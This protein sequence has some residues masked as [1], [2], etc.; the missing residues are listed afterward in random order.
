MNYYLKL[1]NTQKVQYNLFEN[2]GSDFN[3]VEKTNY[4]CVLKL[5]NL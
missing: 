1:S 3:P 2:N 4:I 5:F